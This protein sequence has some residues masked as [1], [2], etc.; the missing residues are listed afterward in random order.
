MRAV[1]AAGRRHWLGL[2]ADGT[3]VPAGTRASGECRV[4]GSTHVVA[5][6]ADNVYPA[7]NTER[8]HSVGLR[9]DG[10]VMATGCKRDAQCDLAS[11]RDV[12]GIAAGWCPAPG[13]V[14]GGTVLA[15]ER[16]REDVSLAAIRRLGLGRPHKPA[17]G[18]VTQ[19]RRGASPVSEGHGYID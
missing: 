3:V 19:S 11:W 15:A 13:L 6:A 4:E 16:L 17:E 2:R 1:I 8:F 9:A 5:V 12:S 14:G 7:S 10:K 18:R